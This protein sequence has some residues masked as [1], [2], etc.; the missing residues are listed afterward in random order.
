M[1][2]DFDVCCYVFYLVLVVV[3]CGIACVQVGRDLNA[4]FVGLIL[5]VMFRL[6]SVWFVLSVLV[7]VLVCFVGVVLVWYFGMGFGYV[8]RVFVVYG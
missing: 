1:I 5:M 4:R 6:S 3:S 2:Y 8:L 7:L